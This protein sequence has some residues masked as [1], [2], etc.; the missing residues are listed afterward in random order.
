M[1]DEKLK[2]FGSSPKDPSFKGGVQ[3]RPI[4]RDCLKRGLEQFADLR[5]DLARN[6]GV[7][8]LRGSA[9]TLMHAMLF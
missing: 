1:N 2:Y 8:F 7:V 6:R 5:G 4:G 9:D 3:E